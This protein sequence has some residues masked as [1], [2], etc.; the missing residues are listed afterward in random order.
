MQYKNKQVVLFSGGYDTS[1]VIAYLLSTKK[2]KQN[3][4]IAL[5]YTYGATTDRIEVDRGK[6]IA[7]IFGVEWRL[8][9]ISIENGQTLLNPSVSDGKVAIWR[10]FKNDYVPMRNPILIFHACNYLM[11]QNISGVL[12]WGFGGSDTYEDT[13]LKFQRRAREIVELCSFG[14]LTLSAPFM[15]L[16]K[17]QYLKYLNCPKYRNILS[18][19]YSCM[20]G[21][22]EHCG[23]CRPCV[24]KKKL[25]GEQFV[26]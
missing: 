14:K 26:A 20:R 4:I 11:T 10:G 1:S 7:Q 19:T 16:Q 5:Q 6:K 21:K 15:K 23:R 9:K 13:S 22:K 25:L 8:K 24:R 3:K 18:L 2:I 12:Y 17:E